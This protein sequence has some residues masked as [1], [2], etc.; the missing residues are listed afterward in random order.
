MQIPVK[1]NLTVEH[2]NEGL[3]YVTSDTPEIKGLLVAGESMA[4]AVREA[5]HKIMDLIRAA[6]EVVQG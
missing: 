5:P 3:W 1:F 2:G 6:N 4:E